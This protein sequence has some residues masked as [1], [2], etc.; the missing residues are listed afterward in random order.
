MMGVCHSAMSIRQRDP[1][2]LHHPLIF[3]IED[4]AMQNEVADVAL[5]TRAYDDRVH[6][7]WPALWGNV[8]DE[9][10]VLPYAFESGVLRVI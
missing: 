3:M 9:E 4:V 6:P 2:V 10:R 8:L 7:R 1:D 5:I